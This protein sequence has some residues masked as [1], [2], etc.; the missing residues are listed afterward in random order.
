MWPVYRLPANADSQLFVPRVPVSEP[1]SPPI[2]RPN[3]PPA[4]PQS[5]L[6]LKDPRILENEKYLG[7]SSIVLRIWLNAV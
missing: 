6:P 1:D 7:F 2:V 3:G 5:R 4:T